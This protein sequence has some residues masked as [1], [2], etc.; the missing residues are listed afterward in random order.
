MFFEPAGGKHC[1]RVFTLQLVSA[2]IHYRAF[3]FCFT[4]DIFSLF[5]DNKTDGL[6]EANNDTQLRLVH[7]IFEK[8]FADSLGTNLKNGGS[9]PEEAEDLL[10]FDDLLPHVGEFGLYQKLLFLFMIPFAFFV[11]WIYFSQF[12]M[13]LVPEN[14]WCRVPQLD[15]TNLTREQ[16]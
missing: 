3:Y 15:N 5:P 2:K 16:R 12:F 13:T 9:E 6:H 7:K 11:A 4:S 8:E 1:A 14:H 10:D